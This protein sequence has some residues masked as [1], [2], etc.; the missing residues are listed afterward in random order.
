MQYLFL[1]FCFHP[2]MHRYTCPFGSH[3]QYNLTRRWAGESVYSKVET[4]L[5]ENKFNSNN[6]KMTAGLLVVVAAVLLHLVFH[7][8]PTIIY[9]SYIFF[10]KLLLVVLLW[11]KYIEQIVCWK[12]KLLCEL[13]HD[14]TNN[15]AVCQAKTLISLGIRPVWSEFS[16]SAWRKLGSLA[17]HWLH[18]EDSDQTGHQADLSLRWAHSHIV[19]LV[20]LW[21]V[22]F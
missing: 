6:H 9:F 16:L 20:M 10:V 3:S 5:A 14:K 22:C 19:G 12:I 1:W 4:F 15:V 13:P 18:S 2:Y 17:T 11:K 8:C 21:L 7:K